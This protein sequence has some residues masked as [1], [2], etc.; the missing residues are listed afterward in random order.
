MEVWSWPFLSID[1]SKSRWEAEVMLSVVSLISSS[2]GYKKSTSTSGPDNVQSLGWL[3]TTHNR[4]IY[5][6]K[7]TGMVA[8]GR[9]CMNTFLWVKKDIDYKRGAICS[10]RNA[11][12]LLEDISR[13][14]TKMLSNRNSSILMMSSSLCLVGFFLESECSFTN[15]LLHAPIPKYLYLRFPFLKV[16]E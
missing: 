6:W 8:E 11:D 2:T 9:D 16:N 7:W 13:K 3:R 1:S 5:K 4:S 12:C 10:Y 15:M 14:T